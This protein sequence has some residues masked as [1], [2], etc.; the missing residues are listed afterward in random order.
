VASSGFKIGLFGA[1]CSGGLALVDAPERW[2]ASWENNL[3]LARLADEAG[4]DCLVPNARW[5]GYGGRSEVNLHSFETITW[6]TGL[7]AA[8]KSIDVYAT[9][10]VPL[11]NPV[12]AAKQL[13]TADH[14]GAGRAGL[15]A[16]LGWNQDEFDMFG[17]VRGSHDDRY[18]LGAEWMQ[19]VEKL[20]SSE[21]EFDHSGDYFDL[22]GLIG[23]PGPVNGSLQIMSA[24]ASPAGRDFAVRYADKHYDFCRR[25]EESTPRIVETKKLAGEIGREIEV[26]TAASVVCRKTEAEAA[27]FVRYCIDNADWGAADNR[28]TGRTAP[29]ASMSE[30][31]EG[32]A[33][34]RASETARAVV[35]RNHY[36]FI[37]DPD[38]IA[39]QMAEFHAAGFDGVAL[40]FVNYL[41][42]L[43]FFAQEVLPR[44]ERLGVRRA[45]G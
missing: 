8:T 5:K 15:N 25:P 21:E 42:E 18:K 35:S 26:W 6:A 33:E 39:A 11:V 13:V 1:N 37:G 3:K 20:W 17:I 34:I 28:D 30:T 23:R 10:H 19:V 43:P 44:L 9:V 16:V 24:G 22:R 14:V 41:D 4:L 45:R 38:S 12:F 40:G 2:D 27:D 7:L 32:I 31:K 29:D 36:T